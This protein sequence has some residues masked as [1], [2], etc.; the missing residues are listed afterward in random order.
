[1]NS[2]NQKWCRNHPESETSLKLLKLL[3]NNHFVHFVCLL[4]CVSPDFVVQIN[5]FFLSLVLFSPVILQKKKLISKTIKYKSNNLS[6]YPKDTY[7]VFWKSVD[8]VKNLEI[9]RIVGVGG[10][11]FFRHFDPMRTKIDL[12]F[13]LK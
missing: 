10:S 4:C 3:M 8:F 2:C 12:W 1:M 6:F 9:T 13:T 5:N 11:C 7:N